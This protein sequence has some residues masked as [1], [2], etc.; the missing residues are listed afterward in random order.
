[1][2]T[3]QLGQQQL[4]TQQV[5]LQQV[6]WQQPWPQPSSEQTEPQQE[7]TMVSEVEVLGGL[8][9]GGLEDLEVGVSL[10]TSPFIPH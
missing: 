9:E 3:Q 8:Q 6:G 10:P 4:H 1:M 5:G 2:D 7:L